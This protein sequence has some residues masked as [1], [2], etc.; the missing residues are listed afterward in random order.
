M[1]FR[2]LEIEHY[3]LF[4]GRQ[5][6]WPADALQLIYGPNEAGKSTLL[7][8]IREVLFGFPVRSP[9]A[10]DEHTGEMAAVATL[11][12]ADGRRLRFR[13]RK[14]RTKEVVGELLDGGQPIDAAVLT[15]LLGNASAELFQHVFGFSLSELAAGQ[16]SL[17]HAKLSEALYG[18]ALGGLAGFRQVL[19]DLE[20]EQERL[21]SPTATKRPINQLVA[22]LRRQGK[23][24]RAA[25]LRPRDY[26]QLE[27]EAEAISERVEGL[28]RDREDLQRQQ[29]RC[30]QLIQAVGLWHCRQSLLN[31]LATLDVPHDFPRDGDAQYGQLQ[32]QHDQIAAELEDFQQ[33]LNELGHQ[34]ERSSP[35][36][37]LIGAGSEI[38]RLAQQLDKIR[39]FRT[40]IDLRRQ[41]S[42]WVKAAVAARLREL[43]PAWTWDHLQRFQASLAR[44][45]A[46]ESMQDELDDLELQRRDL[47]SRCPAL[48]ADIAALTQ[49]LAALSEEATATELIDLVDSA[50]GYLAR[51]EKWRQYAQQQRECSARRDAIVRQLNAPFGHQLANP[52]M[53]PVPMAAVVTEYR[54]RAAELQQQLERSLLRVERAQADRTQQQHELE[55][56]QAE[57]KV[58]DREQLTAVRTR[59]DRGWELVRKRFIEQL[60][61]PPADVSRWMGGGDQPLPDAYEASVRQADDVADERQ[62]QAERVA[63]HEQLGR[64]IARCQGRCEK[65][66]RVHAQCVQACDVWG[67]TWR[68]LWA[69]CAIEPKSPEA[70]L[71]WLRRHEELTAAV[72]QLE[73][74]QSHMAVEQQAVEQFES[75]LRSL[76]PD[77]PGSADTQLAEARRRVQVAQEAA[78]DRKSCAAQ[79][80][81][82]QHQLATLQQELASVARRSEDWQDRWQPLLEE[83]GFP[84]TWDIHTATKVLSGLSEA[85]VQQKEAESLD[86]RVRDMRQGLAQF[87][88]DVA[89]LCSRLA[90]DLCALP[91]EDAVQQLV[92]RLEQARQDA[93]DQQSWKE[94]QLKLLSRCDSKQ[95]QLQRTARS[96]Q[97]L[98]D[99]AAVESREELVEVARRVRRWFAL[100]EEIDAADHQLRAIRGQAEESEFAAE[101]AAADQ[102]ELESRQRILHAHLQ[103]VDQQFN[104]VLEA[105]G[106]TVQRLREMDQA[107][108]AALIA[109]DI[110]STRSRL[111]EAVDQWVPL[112]L[113][114]TFMRRAM[115]HFEREHQPQLLI[116]VGRLLQRMTLGRYGEISR[117][118]DEQGSLQVRQADG[119]LKEPHQLSTGTREQLY[120]AIRLAYVLHYCR[121]AEPLPIVMDDVLVNFDDQRA[122]ETLEAL[123]EVAQHVQVILL[124]CHRGTLQLVQARLSGCSPIMLV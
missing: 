69:P 88:H 28:R 90:A 112:V 18:G 27:Q 107:S 75:Q 17:Q 36:T 120:L 21:F 43:D 105:K 56:L 12:L 101:L 108:Q 31:E 93:R 20:K 47:L 2:A 109:Q 50:S 116:D 97:R 10:F 62:R 74:L 49:Q 1:K 100:R 114:R 55:S 63:R 124:T 94:Q 23:E 22:D 118:L 111:R 102:A 78:A 34:L 96:L 79:L 83:F 8:L 77:C 24:L 86:S 119:K 14:G 42:E 58:P 87:E 99:W 25:Q 29:F 64:E 4:S 9:Y 81:R 84:R 104:E 54:Q 53:L 115:E 98:L 37:E 89:L 32:T 95:K 7:Q 122:A 92:A 45:A 76:L 82:K 26:E 11:E 103:Q 35:R 57:E 52:H 13:R 71:D 33:E 121:E 113:A 65:E 48:E 51:Q 19:E 117:K 72:S 61:V 123:I 38:Q 15:R 85:R 44:R 39:G 3:G 73:L 46:I 91:P 70:M 16:Q 67:Q 6:E 59:R 110:E 41:E 30:G 60:E 68:Q 40:D 80:P 106:V 66:E 5:I